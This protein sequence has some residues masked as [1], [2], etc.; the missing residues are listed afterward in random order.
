MRLW[1]IQVPMPGIPPIIAAGMAIPDTLDAEQ[2]LEYLQILL[3]GFLERGLKI[4]AY[5]ADGSS[6]E[7]SI[8][9]LLEET[10]TG[11]KEIVIQHPS[12]EHGDIVMSIPLFGSQQQPIVM[13]QDSQHGAKTY[14]NNAFSGARLLVL[15]NF[16][17]YYEHFRRLGVE[18]GPLFLRDVE[19]IDRQDDGAATRFFSGDAIAWLVEH[20]PDLLGPIVYLF[21]FGELIDAY[22]NR[23][24]EHIERMRMGLRAYFFMEIW[25]KFLDKAG[26]SKAKHFLSK[27]ACGITH[28]LIQGL[29]KLIII[30]RDHLPDIYPLLLWLLSTEVNEHVYGLCR[31]I[32]PDFTLH[33]F[34]FMVPKLLI[35]LREFA[36]FG[37]F[38][39]GK[40]R[41]SGYAHLYGDTRKINLKALSTFPSNEQ[42]NDAARDAYQ[43]AENLWS[44]LEV[45]PASLSD[46]IFRLPSIQSW[47][48]D[49]NVSG[50]IGASEEEVDSDYE[51]GVDDDGAP[52]DESDGAKIQKALD[53]LEG[54]SLGSFAEEERVNNLAFAAVSLTIN[55]SIAM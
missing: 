14:R 19:K 17:A 13:I 42:I 46:N 1:I 49:D 6:V 21:V 10:A 8:Q 11:H 32:A 43:Q 47:F 28:T 26:Y 30:Y 36:L 51:D 2:L 27:E 29:I 55:T 31:K 16:T 52:F 39:D 44:L 12:P 22:Q 18:N 48:V 3:H 33:D 4:V 40:E 23:H 37:H 15:G 34:I 20:Y 45:V 50:G 9:R 53:E 5:A 24:I 25:E 54:I 7:R 41:A 35:Q 38:S